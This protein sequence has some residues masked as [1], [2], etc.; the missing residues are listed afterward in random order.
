[1]FSTL[2]P[3]FRHGDAA[4][5]NLKPLYGGTIG[6]ALVLDLFY[7]NAQTTHI[8]LAKDLAPRRAAGRVTGS[9]ARPSLAMLN[10]A[11]AGQAA[12]VG[13]IGQFKVM[14]IVILFVSPP[15]LFLR[16]PRHV[17]S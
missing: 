5:F 17:Q 8:V 1:V 10:D 15:V 16:E 7:R 14:R 4:L 12:F 3:A 11:I 9:I 6:V 13:V 2:D